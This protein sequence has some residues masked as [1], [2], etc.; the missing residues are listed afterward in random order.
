MGFVYD[1]VMRERELVEG[2]NYLPALLLT[3]FFWGL[4]FLIVLKV[5]PLILADFPIRG[6]YFLFFLMVF[7]AVLFLS[8]LVLANSRRGLLVAVAVVV[9]GY[10]RLLKLLNPLNLILLI[11]LLIGIEL[12]FRSEK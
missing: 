12:Y 6:S 1:V 8:S 4:V 11:G 2:K 10:L 7:L 3:V 9:I 5:D